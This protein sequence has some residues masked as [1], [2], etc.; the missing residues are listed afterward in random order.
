V[1]STTLQFSAS[2]SFGGGFSVRWFALVAAG[3]SGNVSEK[4]RQR[5]YEELDYIL[6]GE[7]GARCMDDDEDRHQTAIAVLKLLESEL[8]TYACGC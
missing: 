2:M 6:S 1:T 3:G 5:L 8:K 4:E 7:C